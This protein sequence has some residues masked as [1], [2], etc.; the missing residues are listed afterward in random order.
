M[1]L[2]SVTRINGNFSFNLSV[3]LEENYGL[4]RNSHLAVLEYCV[5]EKFVSEPGLNH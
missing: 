1:F 3:G 4:S 5:Y 2:E